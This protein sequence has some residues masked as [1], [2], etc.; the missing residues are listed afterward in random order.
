MRKRL[1]G[2]FAAVALVFAGA[3]LAEEGKYQTGQKE[4][5]TG[6]AGQAGQMQPGMNEI[7]GQ[8]VKVE[9][10]MVHLKSE[11]GAVIPLRLERQTQFQ[12]DLSRENLREGVQIRANFRI[13]NQTQNVATTIGKAEAMPPH[14]GAGGAGMEQFPEQP[15]PEPGTE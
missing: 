2:L 11:E 1:T 3:A 14:E 12:G 4:Q 6:G 7:T 5:P 10:N 15:V 9:R 13:E 8:V